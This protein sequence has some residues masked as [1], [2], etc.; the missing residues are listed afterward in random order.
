MKLPP[1]CCKRTEEGLKKGFN[2]IS[3]SDFKDLGNCIRMAANESFNEVV[4]L[5]Y[6]LLSDFVDR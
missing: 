6:S 1:S 4:I 5:M 2:D 3:V